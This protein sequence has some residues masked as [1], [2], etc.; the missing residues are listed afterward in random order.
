M[1]LFAVLLIASV[2]GVL[3]V[4]AYVVQFAEHSYPHSVLQFFP[5]VSFPGGFLAIGLALCAGSYRRWLQMDV[6]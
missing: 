2:F 3:M 5:L 6:T 1:P 4:T